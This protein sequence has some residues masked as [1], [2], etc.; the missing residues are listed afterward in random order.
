M[1]KL[2]IRQAL[3][4]LA[5]VLVSAASAWA[6]GLTPK[7]DEKKGKWGYVD[8]SG[9]WVIKPKYDSADPFVNG[10]GKVSKSGKWG[11]LNE[12]GKLR[13]PCKYTLVYCLDN[14]LAYGRTDSFDWSIY[15][16][17][18]DNTTDLTNVKI[19]EFGE[20][21]CIL[22]Q[23]EYKSVLEIQNALFGIMFG[24]NGKVIESGFTDMKYLNTNILSVGKGQ[25]IS[26]Y[27]KDGALL[28]STSP[29]NISQVGG[30][31]KLND[32]N[33]Y[34]KQDGLMLYEKGIIG[35]KHIL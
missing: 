27:T 32:A 1:R 9:E 3:L 20:N 6:D 23:V 5:L 7:Q 14:G 17:K 11:V 28:L 15:N 8:A 35:G 2:I 31:V 18:T 30:M 4:A 33:M 25:K 12:A 16:K 10:L 29:S 22:G 13:L 34:V 19:E 24:K 26:L 21:T